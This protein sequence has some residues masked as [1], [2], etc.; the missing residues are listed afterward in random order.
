VVGGYHR[1]EPGVL[2]HRGEGGKGPVHGLDGL[3]LGH[4][5]PA[6]GDLVGVLGMHEDEL[7]ALAE[8]ILRRA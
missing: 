6:V 5:V 3:F 2:P 4:R 1:Q 7:L 8:E